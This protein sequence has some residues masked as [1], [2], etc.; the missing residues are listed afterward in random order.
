MLNDTR[1][2]KQVLQNFLDT[3]P[4][5]SLISESDLNNLSLRLNQV[6]GINAKLVLAPGKEAG[7]SSLAVKVKEAPLINGYASTDNQGLYATVYYQ[8]DD[9]VSINDPFGRGDQLNL[10]AQTTE[11][12]GAVSGWADYNT[13]I[14]G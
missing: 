2:N 1:I 3:M 14:N 12:G 9:G 4:K 13:A 7:T 8:F 6:P 11:T 5:G 10:R